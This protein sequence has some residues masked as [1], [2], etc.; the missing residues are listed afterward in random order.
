MRGVLPTKLR[1]P[2]ARAGGRERGG[3]AN[4]VCPSSKAGQDFGS[5]GSMDV[6]EEERRGEG[7]GAERRLEECERGGGFI[8]VLGE[9]PAAERVSGEYTCVSP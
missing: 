4:L 1:T 3:S 2:W 5:S 7:R 6:E 9:R 8:M